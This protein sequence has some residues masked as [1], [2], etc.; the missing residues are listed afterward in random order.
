[1][2]PSAPE[3]PPSAAAARQALRIPQ[4]G[5]ASTLQRRNKGRIPADSIVDYA[6]LEQ[7]E[8]AKTLLVL[9]L[10]VLVVCSCLAVAWFLKQWSVQ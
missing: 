8:S 1:V 5:D 7:R 9:V 2:P 10:F 4:R 3:L 6:R